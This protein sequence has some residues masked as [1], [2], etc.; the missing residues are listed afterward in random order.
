MTIKDIAPKDDW[1]KKTEHQKM[2]GTKNC[3]KRE[4]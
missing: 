3:T 1:H 2:I 4:I